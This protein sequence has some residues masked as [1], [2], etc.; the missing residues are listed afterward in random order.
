MRRALPLLG[1]LPLL[2]VCSSSAPAPVRSDF[3]VAVG[4]ESFVLR[5]SDPETVRRGLGNMRGENRMFPI[6]PLRPGDGGFNAPWSWHFD[7]DRVRMTEIA[8][9]VCDGRPSCVEEQLQDF[10][11]G[12]CPWGARVVGVR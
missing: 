10:L 2:A 5:A 6:G 9:E 1:F 8:I 7:P 4:S 11:A 12:Y 3:V